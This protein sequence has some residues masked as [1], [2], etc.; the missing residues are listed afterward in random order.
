MKNEAFAV[1]ACGDRD[2]PTISVSKV[3]FTLPANPMSDRGQ[4]VC[5]WEKD[6]N[7]DCRERRCEDYAEHNSFARTEGSPRQSGDWGGYSSASLKKSVIAIASDATNAEITEDLSPTL[8]ARG[9]KG[10]VWIVYEA[11]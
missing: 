6:E 10:G 7:E 11:D 5:L 8:A 9:Y 4:S 1:Q 3:A 2:N